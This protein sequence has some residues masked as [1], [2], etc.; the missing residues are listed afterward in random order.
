MSS[1]SS[2]PT[3]SISRSSASVTSSTLPSP[4]L[5]QLSKP[6]PGLS[7]SASMPPSDGPPLPGGPV[8][9]VEKA[10][11]ATVEDAAAAEMSAV[12][13]AAAVAEAAAAEGAEPGAETAAAEQAVAGTLR[14]RV[15]AEAGAR[16]WG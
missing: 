3:R 15:V 8:H 11:A 10:E 4:L 7:S 13:A 1:A 12:V 2:S 6:P 9:P 5:I 16:G 14:G